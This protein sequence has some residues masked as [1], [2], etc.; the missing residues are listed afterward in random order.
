MYEELVPPNYRPELAA[1]WPITHDT[2]RSVKIGHRKHKLIDARGVTIGTLTR[3]KIILDPCAKFHDCINAHYDEICGQ[4]MLTIS[5][6]YGN[7][8]VLENGEWYQLTRL[9]I[10]AFTI[11][12][13]SRKNMHLRRTSE[14]LNEVVCRFDRVCDMIE[15]QLPQPIA[16]E[17]IPHIP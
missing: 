8:R 16:E 17:I 9:R 11:L 12:H 4:D 2:L 7:V 1:R 13:G 15:T 6:E 10:G 5:V 14:W 3:G